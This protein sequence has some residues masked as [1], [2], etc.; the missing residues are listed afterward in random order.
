MQNNVS[1][2]DLVVFITV[3]DAGGF[4]AAAKRMGVAPS[5]VSTTISRV[6]AQLGI[7]LLMRTTRSVQPTEQGRALAERLVPHLAA[8][9]T[10][11]VEVAQS[12][13]QVSGRLKLNV[14][15]AVVPDILPDILARFRHR[16]PAVML[17][18]V[19][20][21]DLV[22]MIAS[23]CDYGIRYGASLE[24][25][26]ISVPIGPKMQQIALGASPKY[27]AEYGV[28]D[29]PAD[30]IDHHAIRYRLSSGAL[31]PWTLTDGNEVVTIEPK[32]GLTIG[33]NA[34]NGGVGYARA[35]LGIIAS[36]RNWLEDDFEAGTLEPILADW[37]PQ[38]AGPRLYY[39][40]RFAPAP[41]R[42]LIDMIGESG[43][44]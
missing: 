10:A 33:V 32:A 22:D 21:N 23:G 25:D 17:E 38:L 3:L 9:E 5:K 27:L 30:L 6:E 19:V 1:T 39:P 28:P 24:K 40:S 18:I 43:V 26:M 14:P 34:L 20:E 37:W 44:S 16:H 15:G 11:C 31:L 41:L 7:P 36:F 12:A 13:D 42:A 29:T 8:I 35:G 4:R 2:A